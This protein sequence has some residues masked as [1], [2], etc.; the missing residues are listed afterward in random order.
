MAPTP[1]T[2]RSAP[3]KPGALLYLARGG[4]PLGRGGPEM[5]PTPPNFR[6]APGKPVALLYLPLLDLAQGA[7]ALAIA[8]RARVA[9]SS[10]AARASIAAL[11][12][13]GG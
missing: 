1:P 2:L 11:T 3:G 8:A 9:R 10:A 4:A 6:S 12:A 7:S 5:A 13:I